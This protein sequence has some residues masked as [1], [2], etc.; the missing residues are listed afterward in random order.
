MQEVPDTA[1]IDRT[2]LLN[3]LL[4]IGE[5]VSGFSG[6]NNILIGIAQAALN[7]LQ[8]DIVTLY[9]YN[10]NTLD[11]VVPP[12]TVGEIREP[13]LLHTKVFRNEAPWKIVDRG[14][15]HFAPDVES[16]EIMIEDGHLPIFERSQHFVQR[17]GIKS[18]AGLL[19][20]AQDQ[21]VGVMFIS[22]RTPHSFAEDERAVIQ[23]FADTAAIAILN[24]RLIEE[25]RQR[26]ET[27]Q[28][29]ISEIEEK[30]ISTLEL[31]PVLDLILDQSLRLTGAEI[32]TIRLIEEAAN[33]LAVQAHRVT[34]GQRIDEKWQRVRV[35]EGI[36]GRVASSGQ[37]LLI[38]DV[39]KDHRFIRYFSDT[40]S[41]L[42]VPLIRQGK[43][44]GTIN[45]ESPNK[46]A[47]SEEDQRSLERFAALAVIAIQNAERYEALQATRE[48]A[49]AAER[50]A[51]L[52]SLAAN[53]AHR[54]NNEIGTIP[55][56]A[57]EVETIVRPLSFPQHDLVL[58]YLQGIAED[59]KRLMR[60][61]NQLRRPFER[62]QVE[63]VDINLLLA[64][65]V[66][67]TEIPS[68][69]RLVA[70]Y[71]PGP[72]MLAP[73]A[74]LVDVFKNLLENAVEAMS[75]SGGILTIKNKLSTD[76]KWMVVEIADTG[77]GIPNNIRERIFEPFYST[78]KSGMG[79]GLWWCRVMIT[80]IGGDIAVAS[81]QPKG[82]TFS[83]RLPLSVASDEK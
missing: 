48:R 2:R 54:M 78:K 47:F 32:G 57:T 63:K 13:Q 24:T 38:S 39:T 40:R 15:S 70:E 21:V 76:K 5:L 27:E 66:S 79:I 44:I 49:I 17:E 56:S 55:V 37:S 34:P 75:A 64:A 62:S 18:A 1:T 30:V 8:T 4:E 20:K 25:L 22:Y 72:T 6:L 65:A 19:L 7:I 53:F 61:A 83:I 10:Q 71:S 31:Q 36:E 35:G 12:V 60:M 52:N 3:A 26:K 77:I 73:S 42:S 67:Q 81:Q 33:E 45:I 68:H 41:E 58:R 59:S 14:I 16:D 43:V 46:N 29:A 51:V 80:Q 74:Q 82:T 9:E 23:I 50:L 28:R 11:F 69:I